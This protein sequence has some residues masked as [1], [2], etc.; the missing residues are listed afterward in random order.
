MEGGLDLHCSGE[1]GEDVGVK[2]KSLMKGG[3]GQ[4]YTALEE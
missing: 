2:K 1:G 3:K 4:S